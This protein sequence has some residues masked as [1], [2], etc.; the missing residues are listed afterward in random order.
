MAKAVIRI[1]AFNIPTYIFFRLKNYLQRS[2]KAKK[3]VSTIL[4]ASIKNKNYMYV[5]L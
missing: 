4:M 2:N 5:L 3:S 1:V